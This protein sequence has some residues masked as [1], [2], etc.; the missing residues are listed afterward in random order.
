MSV[1]TTSIAYVPHDRQPSLVYCQYSREDCTAM[2]VW[3]RRVKTSTMPATA[4]YYL[5]H[6]HA[7]RL[8]S[9]DGIRL[10]D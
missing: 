4:F 2:A 6:A 8:A 9:D 3:V 1:K 5:C 7:L 10:E